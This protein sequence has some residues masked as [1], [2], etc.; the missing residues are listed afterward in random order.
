MRKQNLLLLLL[1]TA[2]YFS[3]LHAT[4]VS[5]SN[6]Q[7]VALNFFKGSYPAAS[8]TAANLY[9]TRTETDGTVD[10][11]VFNMS[12]AKGFVIVSAD[13]SLT[14]VLAYSSESYFRNDP[15]NRTGVSNW[16]AGAGRYIHAAILRGDQATAA[17]SGIWAA[18]L[19]GPY[20]PSSRS[21]TVDSL[22]TTKWDQWNDAYSPPQSIYNLFCPYNSTDQMHCVT[23]CVATAMGQ[24][25]KYWNYP[26]TGTGSYSYNDAVSNG[27]SYNYGVQSANFAATTYNWTEMPVALTNTTSSS[28]DSAVSL[29]IYQAGVSVGMDY[30]DYNQGGSGSAMTTYD[31]GGGPSA[32]NSYP[33]YFKYNPNT[34]QG[35]QYYNQFTSRYNFTSTQWIDSI[36]QEINAGR[37][38]Q[39]AG[40][41]ATAGGHSWVCDG[42]DGSNNLHMNWGWSGYDDGMFAIT[43]LDPA[44]TG[45]NFIQNQE[46]LTGIEPL[47]QIAAVAAV[48]PVCATHSSQLSVTG[49]PGGSTYAWSPSAGLTCTSCAAPNATPSGTTTYTVTVTSSGNSVTS[50][51]T[52]TVTPVPT[53]PG[54]ATL[55]TAC[56]G[57][58]ASY[59][60]PAVSGATSYI[61]TVSGAGW[62]GGS[63][64]STNSTTLTAGSVTGSVTVKASNTCGT[65]SGYTFSVPISTV[66]SAAAGIIIPSPIC[67]GTS[68][69]FIAHTVTGATSY[70]WS[71]TGLGWTGTSNTSTISL[72]PGTGSATLSVNGVNACGSGTAYTTTVTSLASP[73]AAYTLSSHSVVQS[74]NVFVTFTGT[75]AGGTTYSWNFNGGNATPGTGAGPQTVTWASTGTKTVTLTLDNGGCTSTYTDTV[76]V[77]KPNG[78]NTMDG[79]S[80]DALNISPNPAVAGQANILISMAAETSVNIVV[81]DIAGQMIGTIYNGT[82]GAGEKSIVF[83][84]DNMVSG[85]YLVKVSDGKSFIVKRFVKL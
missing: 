30:E 34:I 2:T 61:W 50:S 47:I 12:P 38:I 11:Y 56:N 24:I 81:Y 84:T 51:I 80:I 28:Q 8:A 21:G 26:T 76:Q 63:T 74:A 48:N 58:S 39:Y 35:Y 78:I 31:G 68:E 17:I 1:L 60:V 52:L 33:T 70:N 57:Q 66:P 72:L 7:T 40:V 37:P 64:T 83:N 18:C 71:V 85:I 6:A 46:I 82:L 23:G 15:N 69:N 5:L 59:S 22:V 3:E 65:S 79:T 75:A 9:Y 73:T 42:Y 49:A 62:S 14:P 41:D 55:P 27:Y 19:Q 10:Y 54:N 36:K 67:S 25:M 44:N 53:T 32:Q 16:M 4:V 77:T 20:A 29:L 13:N 43:A 45:D